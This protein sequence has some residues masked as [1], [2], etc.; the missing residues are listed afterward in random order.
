MRLI[1]RVLLFAIASSL[2]APLAHAEEAAPV[3]PSCEPVSM[4]AGEYV[5]L[6]EDALAGFVN[7]APRQA[8]QLGAL[9]A[10]MQS[11]ETV[12]QEAKN[13]LLSALATQLETGS[14]DAPALQREL[15]T[16]IT[17]WQARNETY[18]AAM[19]GLH[20][21]LDPE[22]RAAF[23]ALVEKELKARAEKERAFLD[24]W[25]R[26]LALSEE[27]KKKLLAAVAS[28]AR[29]LGAER[30]RFESVLAA[31]RGR[32]FEL[33]ELVPKKVDPLLALESA[34]R[35]V[36]ATSQITAILTPE[37]R[38]LAAKTLRARICTKPE[39]PR[40]DLYVF[41]NDGS[42]ASWAGALASVALV[43]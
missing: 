34:L 26:E 36:S 15:A 24:G 41:P 5:P 29:S 16:Y 10:R 31:F 4:Q 11:D 14:I 12:F 30:S 43:D 17:A 38:A 35:M 18:R 39:K 7:L 8:A 42:S 32:K 9:K 27:Q 25:T 6:I 22:Q 3:H 21:T 1:G 23:V 40:S 33:P 28:Q 20:Q 13:Q 37:Q 2:G 19:E